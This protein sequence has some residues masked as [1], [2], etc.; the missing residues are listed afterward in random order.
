MALRLHVEQLQQELM[1]HSQQMTHATE[2]ARRE[3]LRDVWSQKTRKAETL[4]ITN[5]LM[6]GCF[7][8][9][10]PARTLH[11]QSARLSLTDCSQ[12]LWRVCR[13]ATRG[14]S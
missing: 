6:F 1:H 3:N 11:T 8:A 2:T 10:A 9:G 7:F 4:L 13:R 5:T 14:T 12:C